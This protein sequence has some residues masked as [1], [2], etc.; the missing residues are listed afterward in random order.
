MEQPEGFVAPDQEKKVCKL[1]RSLYGLKQAPKQWHLKFDNT[2]LPNGFKINECDKCVYVKGTSKAFVIV[3]L[4]VDNSLI[5]GSSHDTIMDTKRMLKKNFDMKD[6]GTADVIMGIKISRTPDGIILSQ[7][8]Y[9]QKVLKK[10]NAFDSSPSNMPIDLSVNLVAN[11]AEPVAHMEYSG[12]IGCLMYITNYTRPDLAYLVNMLSRF[13]SNPS[14]EHWKALT[15]VLKYLKY[16]LEYGL[17]YSRYPI[18]LEGYSDASWISDSKDSYSTS[19]Y[20]FTIGGGAVSWKSMKQACIARFIMESEFIALDK[21]GEEAEWLQNFLEDIPCWRKPVPSVMIHCDSQTPIGRAQINMYNGKS[22][23]I[24][25]RQ[26]TIRQ[27]ISNGVMSIDYVKSKDK[28]ADPLTKG[29]NR[30]QLSKLL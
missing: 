25:R 26:N 20:I 30:D 10:F 11:K 14:H 23:H 24:R 12:I 3:C 22:Q 18:V 1:I 16:T 28:L 13:M 19:G 9:V 17:Y 5:M 27:L 2:I 6:M 7:S 8:H 4:Y 15:R 29:L 21:A